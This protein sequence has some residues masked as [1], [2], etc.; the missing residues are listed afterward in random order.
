MAETGEALLLENVQDH[1]IWAAHA[2]FPEM[3]RLNALA[4]FPMSASIDTLGLFVIYLDDDHTLTHNQMGIGSAIAKVSSATLQKI[5]LI[6]EAQTALHREKQLNEINLMLNSSTD[7]PTILLCVVRLSAELVKADAG[8]LGVLI[9]SEMMTFY[10]HNIPHQ[11]PLRPAARGRGVAWQIVQTGESILTNDYLSLENAQEKWGQ[12][13][14][15]SF[16]GVPIQAGRECLGALTLFKLGSE[17]NFSQRDLVTV[18]MIGRQAAT[19][20][21]N[22]RMFAEANHRANALANSLNRQE[23][24][25][26]MKNEF[27]HTVS[28]EL[29]SPLGIIYG[30]AELLESGVMGELEEAQLDSIKIITRRV[31]MLND[32]VNDLTA[33]LAAETQEF[34]RELIDTTRLVTAV[35]LDYQM[36]ATDMDITI[37]TELESNLPWL[38]G[39]RTHL[40]RVFDNLFSNAFKFTSQGGTISLNVFTRGSDVLFE[41]SDTGEGIEKEKLPRIFERFYQ[42]QTKGKPRRY[43]TGLGLSL[44]KEIVEAHR[45]VVSVESIYG[46]GTTF[47]IK[48]PGYP[49]AF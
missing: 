41:L 22:V 30:H 47:C 5:Q 48:L 14:I 8:L 33:L 42:V 43:G 32:L 40:Q 34:R 17:E 45:G 36:K 25:D 16:M 3:N 24:L 21:H 35:A 1:A 13:R 10:P 12:M 6:E 18:E 19:T 20:M 4:I 38:H 26:K 39:D 31:H 23:E 7:L 46:Q 9:D 11:I 37:Q 44:V 2:Q 15:S 27:I 49:P 29:R 28:H